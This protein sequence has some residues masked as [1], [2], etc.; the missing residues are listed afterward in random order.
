[1]G[2]LIQSVVQ[3]RST[4]VNAAQDGLSGAKTTPR[5]HHNRPQVLSAKTLTRGWIQ[6]EAKHVRVL[7]ERS[8]IN[9]R[10][11][12]Y[13]TRHVIM[14]SWIICTKATLSSGRSTRP[15]PKPMT[16]PLS[17]QATRSTPSNKTTKMR[18]IAIMMQS[19]CSRIGRPSSTTYRKTLLQA[20]SLTDLEP[21]PHLVISTQAILASSSTIREEQL[22]R[23]NIF[24]SHQKIRLVS[25][26][27]KLSQV[28]L[29]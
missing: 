28:N 25:I 2:W 6:A 17:I 13:S 22:A 14:E 1:M 20:F 24:K 9:I 16:K 15:E 19:P 3:R 8:I 5:L 23:A 18:L 12:M 4:L 7:L 21:E 10:I 26:S 29:R 27:R 11:T